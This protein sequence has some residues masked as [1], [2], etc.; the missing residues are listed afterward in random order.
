MDTGTAMI[1]SSLLGGGAS[2]F[3][4]QKAAS[5]QKESMERLIS[6]LQGMYSQT[7]SDLAPYRQLGESSIPMIEALAGL[8]GDPAATQ[9]ALENLPG[10]QFAR[11]Q[12]LKSVQNSAAA[13]GLGSSGAALKGAANFATGLADQ[14]FG[15]QFNRIMGLTNLGQTAAAQGGQIGTSYAN[16]LSGA[17]TGMGNAG[18][19]GWNSLA[20]AISGTGQNISNAYLIQDLLGRQSATAP[21]TTTAPDFYTR[22][23]LS[24]G[25]QWGR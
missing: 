17:Y 9:T 15:N 22:I 19:A 23:P 16:Q 8:S 6:A 2:L 11:T 10:Y 14:T 5:A 21:A 3:G 12:G 4:S 7:R 13:R 18:A 24:Y 25:D 20:N 1:G